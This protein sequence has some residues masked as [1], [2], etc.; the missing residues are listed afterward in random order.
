M[1]NIF[2]Y[3]CWR[4][5]L[6]LSQSDFNEVDNLVLSTLCYLDFE[7][8]VPR[9]GEGMITIQ[10]AANQYFSIHGLPNCPDEEKATPLELREWMLYLMADTR[11]FR[12]MKLCN[13]LQI[14]DEIQVKQFSSLTIL[15]SRKH[16]YLSYRGT[17]DDLIGW[18]ED[19]LLACLPEIPAQKS[20]IRVLFPQVFLLD[21]I[22]PVSK[23]DIVKAWFPINFL[24]SSYKSTRMF[25]AGISLR[26]NSS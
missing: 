14:L 23:L 25:N 4:G 22:I 13:H 16:A 17:G 20:V 3:L 15:V 1:N 12:N 21:G 24:L 11:R 19:F 7:E 10:Q 8:I 9:K 2:G 5:D 18:K 6:S 26:V